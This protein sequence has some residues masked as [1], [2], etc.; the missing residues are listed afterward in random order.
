MANS[1]SE[2]LYIRIKTDGSGGS[3]GDEMLLLRDCAIIIR[4]VG[5]G[6]AEKLELSSK[7]LESTPLQNKKN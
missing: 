6:E 2:T 5:G 4:R 1:R 7:N 3:M